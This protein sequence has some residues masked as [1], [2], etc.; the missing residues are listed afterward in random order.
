[1]KKFQPI[2]LFIFLN[3]LLI[4][5]FITIY[6]TKSFA[7]DIKLTN[8]SELNLKIAQ[9]EKIGIYV[10]EDYKNNNKLY[11]GM[12]ISDNPYFDM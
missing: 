12:E 1:M 2:N 5:D 11:C 10:P 9:S 3:G 8:Q 6:T 4:F 7:K